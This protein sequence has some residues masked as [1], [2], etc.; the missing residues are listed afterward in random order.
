MRIAGSAR[1]HGITDDQM[2]HAF[3]QPIRVEPLD[4]GF[5]MYIGADRA[6]NLLEIGVVNGP[7]GALIVHAMPARPRFL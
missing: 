2:R 3:R 7:A 6:G 5:T 4:D 1:R